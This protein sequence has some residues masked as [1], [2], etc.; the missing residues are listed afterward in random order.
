MYEKNGNNA[1][2]DLTQWL[3]Y[4]DYQCKPL[5]G[6]VK[7]KIQRIEQGGP[8]AEYAQADL[9]AIYQAFTAYEE[10]KEAIILYLNGLA[11]AYLAERGR[12]TA[13]KNRSEKLWSLGFKGTMEAARMMG[14]ELET[15]LMENKNHAL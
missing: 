5:A 10:F 3:D 7:A 11:D 2:K 8:G 15:K 6:L 1:I 13:Y 12:A 4:I 14:R 9:D